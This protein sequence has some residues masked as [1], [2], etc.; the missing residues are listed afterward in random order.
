MTRVKGS[1][2]AVEIRGSVPRLPHREIAAFVRKTVR[3]A[4]HVG[5]ATYSPGEVSIGLLRDDEMIA[6]NRRF[7]GRAGTTDVLTFPAVERGEDGDPLGDIAISLDQA[8]RQAGEE[9]HSLP[10]EIRYLLVH[11]VL[12]AFGH[13]HEIDAGEMNTLEERVR[14]MVGL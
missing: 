2:L 1:R 11:G 13:D 3:A 10:T 5:A 7:R 9:K 14:T 12:H 4:E 6:L 8:R